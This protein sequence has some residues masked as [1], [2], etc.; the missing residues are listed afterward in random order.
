MLVSDEKYPY[1]LYVV[2]SYIC[3][4]DSKFETHPDGT[5][6]FLEYRITDMLI[7]LQ[8]YLFMLTIWY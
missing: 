5:Y 6:S 7:D 2:F 8:I 3:H 4:I 1:L